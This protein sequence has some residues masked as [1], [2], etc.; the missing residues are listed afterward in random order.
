MGPKYSQNG[1]N[2][3]FI[4]EPDILLIYTSTLGEKIE[5]FFV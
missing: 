4:Y 5:K 1:P 3:F 2:E